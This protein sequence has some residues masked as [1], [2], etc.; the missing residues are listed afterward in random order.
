M[1]AM[2][3]IFK[4]LRIFVKK[5]R[6]FNYFCV[7]A[8]FISFDLLLK[9]IKLDFLSFLDLVRTTSVIPQ[10]TKLI[11]NHSQLRLLILL[12]AR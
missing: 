1:W 6:N 8:F 11:I 2:K 5:F 12:Q 10:A 9:K 7:W 3:L 4:F